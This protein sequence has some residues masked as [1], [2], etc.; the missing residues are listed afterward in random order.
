MQTSIS[1]KFEKPRF[2]EKE[3]KEKA[4]LRIDT[5]ISMFSAEIS[6]VLYSR[7]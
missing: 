1:D 4:N 7:T 6:F 5:F 2:R 3:G